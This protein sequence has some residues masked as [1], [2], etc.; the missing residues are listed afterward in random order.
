MNWGALLKGTKI[1]RARVKSSVNAI[2]K[3]YRLEPDEISVNRK[4]ISPSKIFVAALEECDLEEAKRIMKQKYQKV[5]PAPITV[6][7]YKKKCA[8]FMGSNRS[9]VFALKGKDPDCIV[10]KLPEKMKE[11]RIVSEAKTTLAEILAEGRRQGFKNIP[12]QKVFL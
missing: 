7:E 6:L 9:I 3:M 1:D 8:L 11:P 10:V 2:L 4:K 5:L 12:R